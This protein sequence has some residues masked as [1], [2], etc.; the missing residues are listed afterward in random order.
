MQREEP[1]EPSVVVVARK[2]RKR[3][4]PDGSEVM[5]TMTKTVRCSVANLPDV[6]KAMRPNW[7][8]LLVVEP[9]RIDLIDASAAAHVLPD[10]PDWSIPPCYRLSE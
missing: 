5:N 9:D 3:S 7:S 2:I 10:Q 1:S 8:T 4:M 6:V